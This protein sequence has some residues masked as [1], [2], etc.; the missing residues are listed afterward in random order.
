MVPIKKTENE[1]KWWDRYE[2]PLSDSQFVAAFCEH[3]FLSTKDRS[4]T[5]VRDRA[6]RFIRNF[7]APDLEKQ[8]T[9]YRK[10][11]DDKI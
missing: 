11:H 8:L 1:I 2:H 3:V 6:F 10:V 5:T 4:L 7:M 9:D